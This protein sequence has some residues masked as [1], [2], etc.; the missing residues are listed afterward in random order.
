MAAPVS[1]N[2][3]RLRERLDRFA[4]VGATGRSGVDRQ[5]FTLRDRQA[6]AMLSELALARGFTVAQD[7][8]ANLF[9]RRNGVKAA[10]APFLIGSHLDTQPT[11]GR[12]DGA[13]GV[14]AAF[15]AL[16]ALEDAGIETDVPVEM[17]AWTNEEGCRFAPGS[18]GSQAFIAAQIPAAMLASRAPDGAIM[19]DELAATLAALP[20]ASRRPLGGDL[21]GYLEL[22]IEQGPILERQGIPLGVV[23]AVQGTRWL[24]VRITG[25]SAH[26]GTTP[27][28]AR[29]DPMMAMTAGLA[30]LYDEVMPSDDDAR[31]TVGRVSCEPGSVNAV[32]NLVTFSIDIRHPKLCA[33]D[34]IEAKIA[35]VLGTAAE[36]R[37]CVLAIDRVFDMPPAE[38]SPL[39]VEAIEQTARD[40]GIAHRRMVSGAFHDALFMARV[41]PAAML[42]VP[43]RDG[44]SHNEDEFVEP[45]LAALGADMLLHATL[46]AVDVLNDRKG[47]SIIQ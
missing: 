4:A 28:A 12:F 27:L 37:G 36:T 32:P 19:A 13:L 16:E 23:T 2:S 42:F 21:R 25:R 1:I 10:A 14:L 26:A 7:D 3:A 45:E 47:A 41:T 44:I 30:A 20:Q 18:M 34:A 15:E 5:A 31:M 46:H 43:C 6:R 35:A 24:E 8:I 39:L 22:H 40:R 17:V 38:F 29:H 9:I 11:G 33:L